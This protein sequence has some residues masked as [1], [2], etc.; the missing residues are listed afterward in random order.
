MRLQL[1]GDVPVVLFMSRCDWECIWE[2][3]PSGGLSD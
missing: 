2:E 3:D 1:S